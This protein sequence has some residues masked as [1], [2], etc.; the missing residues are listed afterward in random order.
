MTKK[1]EEAKLCCC[2]ILMIIIA[3][4]YYTVVYWYIVLPALAL[5]FGIYYL[6]K[7]DAKKP[8]EKVVYRE[9]VVYKEKESR[10]ICPMC[11]TELIDGHDYCDYCGYTWKLKD[12]TKEEKKERPR[13]IPKK[14]QREVWRRDKG[15]CVECGSKE[16]LEYDHIIP[17]SRG[18]SNT[19]RNIQLLCE[20]CNKKKSNKI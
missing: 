20:K 12:E 6:Y 8:K 10:R 7:Q 16:N 14:V 11:R 2:M 13:I 1:E 5:I 4:I 18:G 3:I 17:F 19:T 15:K 9:R